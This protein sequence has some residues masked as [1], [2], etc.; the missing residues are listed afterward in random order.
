[1]KVWVVSVKQRKIEQDAVA[2]VVRV[3]GVFKTKSLA[4]K[5]VE[6]GRL[7]PMARFV[8]ETELDLKDLILDCCD[9]DTRDDIISNLAK[10]LEMPELL[11]LI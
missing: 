7:L 2:E 11:E 9:G 1:M 8:E 4:E 3:V 5:T 10:S 6:E